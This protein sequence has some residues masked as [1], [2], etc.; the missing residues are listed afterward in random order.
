MVEGGGVFGEDG[1]KSALFQMTSLIIGHNG[2]KDASIK[3]EVD[4]LPMSSLCRIRLESSL[5]V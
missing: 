3:Y 5:D 1:W 4:I 2:K